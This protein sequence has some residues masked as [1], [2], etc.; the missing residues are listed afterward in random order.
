M[1]DQLKLKNRVWQWHINE[2]WSTRDF[3]SYAPWERRELEFDR[4]QVQV[5]ILSEHAV[6][7]GLKLLIEQYTPICKILMKL[8][9]SKY[10]EKINY[11]ME[12]LYTFF[13]V[14]REWNIRQ[15]LFLNLLTTRY[16]DLLVCDSLLDSLYKF[17]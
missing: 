10:I 11:H 15:G 17:K 3:P 6:E 7:T 4:A 2:K 14:I 16:N 5:R 12:F 1:E 8:V 9:S 13:R